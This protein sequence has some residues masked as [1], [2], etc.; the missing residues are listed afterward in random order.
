MVIYHMDGYLHFS[1]DKVIKDIVLYNMDGKIL[2]QHR[3][4][5]CYFDIPFRNNASFPMT[6]QIKLSDGKMITRKIMITR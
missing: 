5:S 1:S 2:G 6:I 4:N 3:A